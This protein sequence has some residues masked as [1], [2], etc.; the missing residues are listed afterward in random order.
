[1]VQPSR[2][3][4]LVVG[5]IAL[6][7]Q[8]AATEEFCERLPCD[9]ANRELVVFNLARVPTL[10]PAVVCQHGHGTW[11][12]GSSGI[13]TN[14]PSTKRTLTSA[15]EKCTRIKV[16][17]SFATRRV[18]SKIAVL[19]L[20]QAFLGHL[21]QINELPQDSSL[22]TRE[23]RYVRPIL[24]VPTTPSLIKRRHRSSECVGE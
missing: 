23:A 12:R 20:K 11:D 15:F 10:D 7:V 18:N 17:P 21:M 1:M 14:P 6:F 5:P 4:G 16:E 13:V 19:V 2:E 9:A 3:A 22:P 24:V 8:L